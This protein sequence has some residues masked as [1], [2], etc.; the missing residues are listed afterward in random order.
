V[1]ALRSFPVNLTLTAIVLM[2][3]IHASS[4]GPER[5]DYPEPERERRVSLGDLAARMV[6]SFRAGYLQQRRLSDDEIVGI[7]FELGRRGAKPI[8]ATEIRVVINEITDEMPSPADTD[9]V[10]RRLESAGWQVIDDH[11]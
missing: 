11:R 9:R 10:R 3:M 6:A 7:A 1:P 4:R 8:G 2:N 5:D